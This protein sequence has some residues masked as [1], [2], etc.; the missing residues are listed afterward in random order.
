MEAGL[1]FANADFVRARIVE[2]LTN[3]TQAVILDGE[4][5]PFIDV[6]GASMLV[7]VR[8]DLQR[9]GVDLV[10]ARDVGQVRD[11]VGK[12][13]ESLRTDAIFATVDDAYAATVNNLDR[14]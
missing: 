2:S 13:E 4:T 7:Q 8:N 12:T 5:T 14:R 3:T 1:F 11:V 9:R 6:T 10:L